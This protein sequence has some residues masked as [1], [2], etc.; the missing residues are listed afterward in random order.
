MI[1]QYLDPNY[2]ILCDSKE[3]Q[4][5]KGIQKS[6]LVKFEKNSPNSATE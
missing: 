5:I 2:L 6:V 4:R 1:A 3:T